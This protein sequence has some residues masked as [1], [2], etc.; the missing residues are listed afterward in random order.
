MAREPPI[1]SPLDDRL[2]ELEAMGGD[3]FFLG[4]DPDV[5]DDTKKL[6]SLEEE[7]EDSSTVLCA[8]FMVAAA[9]L[10]AKSPVTRFVTDG[11]GP[12][13]KSPPPPSGAEDEKLDDWVWDGIV[14]EDAHLDLED[15]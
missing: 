12:S 11:L 6:P 7:N 14:N 15:W 1:R 9:T 3:P 8:E 13:P 10:S 2:A 4:D 5:D